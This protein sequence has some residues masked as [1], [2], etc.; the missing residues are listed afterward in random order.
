MPLG[1]AKEDLPEGF[2]IGGL[3]I[4]DSYRTKSRDE[5]FRNPAFRP[6]IHLAEHGEDGRDPIYISD[7]G[8]D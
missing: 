6:L 8:Y 5:I 2:A 7:T 1:P 3:H 4:A